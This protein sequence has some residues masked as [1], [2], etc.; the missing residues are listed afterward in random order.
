MKASSKAKNSRS[1]RSGSITTT[2]ELGMLRRM[3]DMSG[4]CPL[5]LADLSDE[6]GMPDLRMAT[7]VSI[8]AVHAS[9][10][11]VYIFKL[12]LGATLVCWLADPNDPEI[13]GLLRAWTN[14]NYM[15]A[16]L[17]TRNGVMVRNRLVCGA[18]PSIEDIH[19]VSGGM[20]TARFIRSVAEIGHSAFIKSRTQSDITSVKKIWKV[21]VFQI[22]GKAAQA[23]V[24]AAAE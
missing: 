19:A 9:E 7:S 12:Q 4:N 16:A 23:A 21:R 18:P 10:Q 15:F 24:D 11:A 3:P 20:D 17:K 22:L 14:A 8:E 6:R 13:D 5:V 2:N 1:L